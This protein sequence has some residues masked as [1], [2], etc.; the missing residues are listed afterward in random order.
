MLPLGAD[1]AAIIMK[2]TSDET[3]EGKKSPSPVMSTSV[4]VRSGDTWKAAF[5]DEVAVVE[6]KS[7]AGC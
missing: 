4:Y 6:M 3:C 7:T 5:H 1:A 2:V